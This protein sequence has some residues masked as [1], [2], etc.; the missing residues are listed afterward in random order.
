[1]I[2]DHWVVAKMRMV[3]GTT[4]GVRADGESNRVI[5]NVF[6]NIGYFDEGVL[7]FD[8]ASHTRVL[9]NYLFDYGVPDENNSHG[10]Y[11]GGV[12][13]TNTDL[14]VAYNRLV[15]QR[16]GRHIQLY[17]HTAGERTTNVRIHHNDIDTGPYDESCWEI[18][19]QRE[20]VNGLRAFKSM[21]ILSATI[22]D[23][24]FL[25]AQWV[26]GCRRVSA[27]TSATKVPETRFWLLRSRRERRK[28]IRIVS[29]KRSL[30]SPAGQL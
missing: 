11:H 24:V 5:G 16:D 21:I 14:E 29:I 18:L 19:M 27:I 9:G 22:S 10:I 3:N 12:A 15:R 17:G 25:W 7:T 26:R 30:M 13:S 1:M 23:P 20:A 4:V 28:S 2:G 6:T 8:E